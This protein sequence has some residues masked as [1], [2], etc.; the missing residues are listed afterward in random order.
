MDKLI[1]AIYENGVFRPTEPI[2]ESVEGSCVLITIV[3][4][5]DKESLQALAGSISAEDAEEM[6]RAT[7]R[8]PLNKDEAWREHEQLWDSEEVDS[9]GEILTREQLH[10][11]R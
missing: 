4:P 5:L 1:R 11:R 7:E 2:P 8:N 6:R 9:Q 3:K 10:A